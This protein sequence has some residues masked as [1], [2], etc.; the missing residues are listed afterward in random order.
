MIMYNDENFSQLALT[1]FG[2][3]VLFWV[4]LKMNM[5]MLGSIN[6]KWDISYGVYL[7]GWP[8][9][10]FIIWRF[11]VSTPWILAVLTLPIAFVFGA[12]SWFLVER[13]ARDWAR[14]VTRRMRPDS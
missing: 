4:A 8:I 11:H 13:R 5:G 9:S 12:G 10:T 7:Y 1:T 2:A 6:D 3:C 14:T